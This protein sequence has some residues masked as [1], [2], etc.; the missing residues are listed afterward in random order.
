MHLMTP[1]AE[2]MRAAVYR[3]YGGARG[4]PGGDPAPP[5]AWPRGGA[6][7]GARQHRV[8]GRLAVAQPLG[9]YTRAPPLGDGERYDVI[10]ETVGG[11][12]YVACRPALSAGGRLVLCAG[13]LPQIL[14]S[15]VRAIGT[16]HRVLAGA[17]PE[18][19]ADL[20]TLVALAAAGRYA[21]LI[22]R[23][24]PLDRIAEAHA[25]V[26]TGRKLGSVVVAMC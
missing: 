14:G 13:S 19:P 21:P 15:L 4:D 23:T 16:S 18:R 8:V 20:A 6:G 1:P 25:H 10:V 17:A 22:D 3:A 9:D 11:L 12:D 5:E 2:T 24:Y 26:D 7:E